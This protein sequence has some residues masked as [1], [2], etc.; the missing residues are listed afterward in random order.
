MP[1]VRRGAATRRQVLPGDAAVLWHD[2]EC[3]SYSADLPL[4]RRLAAEAGGLVLD[5][6]CG[7]GRVALDLAERGRE[8]TA[9][10]IDPRFVDE[11]RRRA[12]ERDLSV[13]AALGDVRELRVEGSFALVL[14]PM[15]LLQIVGGAAGRIAM[16]RG[17]Q[18]QLVPGGRFAAAITPPAAT[19]AAEDEVPPLP[20][21]LERDGWVL[22]SYPLEIRVEGGG[23][24][25][26]RLRRL[27]SPGGEVSDERNTVRL[28]A[29]TAADLEAE[30]RQ[31]GLAPAGLA[32]IPE[33][34]DHVGSTVV[35]LERP[36]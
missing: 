29:V 30:G 35:I 27:V 1:A 31:A 34:A 24:A 11:L 7:T 6:G 36:A 20:D 23:V 15:Q 18:R 17:V 33:T 22:S 8:V 16:L 12:R 19:A 21:E 28:D 4:W 25:V 32:A 13:S 10:D 2:V 3:G 5:L 9:V 14:A 26:E